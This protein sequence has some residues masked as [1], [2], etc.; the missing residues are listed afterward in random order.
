[1][2][3]AFTNKQTLK[4]SMGNVDMFAQLLSTHNSMCNSIVDIIFIES[5]APTHI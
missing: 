5:N 3:Q 2:S 4:I 1:M